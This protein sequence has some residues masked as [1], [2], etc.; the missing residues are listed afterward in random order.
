[1]SLYLESLYHP[2]SVI[3]CA[4]RWTS[5][6]RL[7]RGT[8]PTAR[9]RS[10]SPAKPGHPRSSG[11]LRSCH[12]PP[13]RV[14]PVCSARLGGTFAGGETCPTS[15]KAARDSLTAPHVH[16]P[17]DELAGELTNGPSC[18]QTTGKWSLPCKPGNRSQCANRTVIES[19]LKMRTVQQNGPLLRSK[20]YKTFRVG[21]WCSRNSTP[22]L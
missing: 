4:L 10:N 15:A 6:L 21:C 17:A 20:S 18:S 11:P 2:M 16:L 5:R 7:R 22:K 14:G 12:G 13:D 1:M 19:N 9:D 3:A 8:L